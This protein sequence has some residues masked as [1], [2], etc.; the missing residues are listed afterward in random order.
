MVQ[1]YVVVT[2]ELIS[3]DPADFIGQAN[4]VVT[5]APGVT[6]QIVNVS[7][8]N[9]DTVENSE[10]FTATLTAAPGSIA[11]IGAGGTATATITDDDSKSS[12]ISLANHTTPQSKVWEWDHA[13]HHNTV[14]PL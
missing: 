4:T 3:S 12:F 10:T 2:P 9:D 1:C 5:F 8:V 6:E 7:V 11:T 14:S 13:I